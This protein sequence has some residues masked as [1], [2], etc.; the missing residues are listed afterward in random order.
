[1]SGSSIQ[2]VS[3]VVTAVSTFFLLGG[4]WMAFR[5][6]RQ[7]SRAIKADLLLRF[8]TEW[9]DERLYEAVTYLHRVRREW[10][11]RGGHASD[12]AREWVDTNVSPSDDPNNGEGWEEGRKQNWMHRRLV[13]QYMRHVAYLLIKDY[14]SPDDVFSTNPEAGRL[15]QVL[16]PLENAVIERYQDNDRRS[17][18]NWDLVARKW[19]LE[20]LFRRY[21]EWFGENE[22]RSFGKHRSMPTIHF[23]GDPPSSPSE[24]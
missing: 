13:A 14:L 16:I 4:V 20:E 5:Q 19:E 1:M 7:A 22:G 3:A 15:L 11:M 2:T 21:I 23:P 17:G 6:A 18:E 24:A 10:V 9:R 8:N 12:L